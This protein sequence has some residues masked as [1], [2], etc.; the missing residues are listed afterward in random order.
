MKRLHWLGSAAAA[1][2]M[3]SAGVAQASN[4][5]WS[6]GVHQPGVHV[7][8]SN[9]PPVVVQYPVVVHNPRP[10]VVT[11]PPHH[12]GWVP[13][14]HRH[15]KHKRYDKSRHQQVTHVHH[16]HYHG[17]TPVT[18]VQSAPPVRPHWR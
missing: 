10:V 7:G 1:I 14:G 4:V 9:A 12:A 6:I 13:P 15:A 16:H 3:S 11:S 5:Y 2:V 18:I 17:S 8:V